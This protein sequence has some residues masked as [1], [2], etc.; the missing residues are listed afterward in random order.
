MRAPNPGSHAN[1]VSGVRHGPHH[2]HQPHHLL[3]WL[4]LF[5]TVFQTFL[6]PRVAAFSTAA[7]VLHHSLGFPWLYPIKTIS[8]LQSRFSLYTATPPSVFKIF[9]WTFSLCVYFAGPCDFLPT[10]SEVAIIKPSRS[11]NSPQYPLLS[12][13][14]PLIFLQSLIFIYIYIYTRVSLNFVSISG[15][16]GARAGWR[17]VLAAVGVSDGRWL[18][19]GLQNWPFQ[20]EENRWFFFWVWELVW[21]QLGSE[22]TGWVSHGLDGNRERRRWLY[23]RV[24]PEDGS[25]YFAGHQFVLWLHCEGIY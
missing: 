7:L 17:R 19:D 15:C 5:P 25:F 12:K 2:H 16:Y 23:L 3:I 24:N 1:R 18:V 4:Q 20:N 13:Y 14:P 9:L 8:S 10:I 6:P 21:F 22:F 11:S